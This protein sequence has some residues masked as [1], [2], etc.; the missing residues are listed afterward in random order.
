M[1]TTTAAIEPT[2]PSA[3]SQPIAQPQGD[4]AIAPWPSIDKYPLVIGPG[5]SLTYISAIFRLSLIGYRQQYVD[6]LEEMLEKDPGAFSVLSKRVLGVSG[7][8]V[9]LTP[10]K[11]EAG[12]AD[13]KL[14]Q[15]V[16]DT[17]TA[18]LASIPDL[19]SHLSSLAW[20]AYYAISGLETHW[21]RDGAGWYPER[22]SFVHSRRLAYPVAGSWDLYV[23]DQG[24]VLP[25]SYYGE[26]ATNSKVFGLRVADAPG[27]FI[28]HAPQIRGSYPTREGLGR[29]IAYWM[30]L[31]LIATRAAPQYLQQFAQPLPE[32]TF[33][34]GPEA[35]RKP[36]TKEDIAAAKDAL[37]A[38]GAGQLRSWVHADTVKLDLRTPDN[39][40]GSKLT[41]AEWI[42]ICNAEISKAVL[43]GTLSTEV[44]ST[45]GNRA[46]GET[47]KKSETQLL[48]ND[49]AS[50]AASLRRDLVR[51]MVRLN[52]PNVPDRF[53]PTVTIHVED[54]P[55]PM[56]II[57]RASKG[58]QAGMP[59]DADAVAEQAGVPLIKI[60]DTKARR[61]FPIGPQ[62][63]PAQFDADL[64]ERREAL[65]PEAEESDPDELGADEAPPPSSGALPDTDDDTQDDED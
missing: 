15:E 4:G 3:V 51:W 2:Q 21:V 33:S 29:Q 22:L 10:A 56:A 41:F 44:G 39:G 1:G 28:I 5:L 16:S 17:C 38:M 62:K 6:L 11:A 37:N 30:A 46:L 8:R 60:G 20:A 40:I 7:G 32:A 14:A 43:G 64:A 24:G 25:G 19:G 48:R 47:Q 52:F 57:D 65:A 13:E 34:T 49:A 12:S 9:E 31:K 45:G 54:A 58:A 42:G 55:D 61:M 59:V 18:M 53:V 50:L 36:A 35:A 26:S 23:W 27:K 63:D